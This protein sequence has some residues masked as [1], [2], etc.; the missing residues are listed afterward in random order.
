MFLR[1]YP[2][3]LIGV[4]AIVAL[5]LSVAGLYGVLAFTV[6]SR[7]RELGVR[8]ALGAT[9]R[10]LTGLVVRHG[11]ALAAAGIAA[12]L[13]V[14]LAGSRAI[15]GLLYG[16][17]AGDPVTLLGV[18]VGLAA[19]TLGASWIPARRASRLNPLIALKEE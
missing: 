13:L 5:I 10:A 15:A 7:T 14:S 19:I 8:A 1:R 9:P 3:M 17:P 18:A 16:V 6:T 11:G 2:L 4:F 12:G